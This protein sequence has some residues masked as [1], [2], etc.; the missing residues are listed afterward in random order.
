MS[1]EIGRR[2]ALQ[3]ATLGAAT[4]VVGAVGTWR[5][6]IAPE[7]SALDPQADEGLREP[8]V[9]SSR[10]GVL[11]VDLTAAAGAVMAGRLTRALGYNGTSPGPTLRVSPG[12]VLRVELANNLDDTTNLHTHGLHVSPEGASDNVFRMVEP[13]DSARYEYTIPSDHP[14]GTFWYHPHHHGTVA[15][16]M[17]GGLFGALLVAG[18]DDAD[19]AQDRVLIVSDTTLTTDGE[20]APVSRQ[21]VMQGR[22]GELVLVNGQLRPRIDVST[23]QPER[24][25]VVNACTSRFLELALDQHTWGFLGYD[26]QALGQPDERDTVVLA[27]GN[28]V[29]VLVQPAGVGT[30][31]LRTLAHDRGG[32]GMMGGGSPG[33]SA[34]T[35]LAT[36]R[37]TG[38]DTPAAGPTALPALAG[39]P[40]AD[41]ADLRGETVGARRTIAFTMGMRRRRNVVRFRRPG[42]RPRPYRPVRDTRHRRGVDH[43]KHS[44]RW[45]APSTCTCGRCRSW[46]PP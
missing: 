11:E 4:A 20:V 21:Q 10:D 35:A 14:T 15:D 33:T 22:E 34:E 42:V 27:P 5:S 29:D 8:L 44:H 46:K 7:T 25:R 40:T 39:P 37:V 38:D 17:F 19:T 41:V 28:R 23:D 12:D 18:P 6:L 30:F 31:T 9:L 26:G 1:T 2:R 16:Q 24:W 45:T 43:R 32:M 13:G 36:M 3:I